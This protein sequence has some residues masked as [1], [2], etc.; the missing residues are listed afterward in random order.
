M[1]DQRAGGIDE[2]RVVGVVWNHEAGRIGCARDAHRVNAVARRI[3]DGEA[4]LPA[5]PSPGAPPPEEATGPG[6]GIPPN[7]VAG[8]GGIDYGAMHA[9]DIISLRESAELAVFHHKALLITVNKSATETSLYE[10]TRWAWKI[11]KAKAKQAEVILA[12]RLGLIIGAFVADDWLG[13]VGFH[14]A[15]DT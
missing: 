6:R 8:T 10:A 2:K 3:G 11:N 4:P 14:H 12:T 15:A 9:R 13:V 7:V 5:P 1:G